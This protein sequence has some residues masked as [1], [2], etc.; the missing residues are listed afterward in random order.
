M[1]RDQFLIFES[2]ETYLKQ[3]SGNTNNQFNLTTL[4]KNIK[5]KWNTAYKLSGP[6]SSQLF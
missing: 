6:L 1:N 2:L 4:H 5:T 3:Q